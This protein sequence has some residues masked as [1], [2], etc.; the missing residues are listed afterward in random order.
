MERRSPERRSIP[1]PP[2]WLN[3][4]L[5]V[6]AGATFAYA[7]HQRNVIVE[8]S[9]VLFRKSENSPSELNRIRDELAQMDLT[10][11]QLAGELAGRMAFLQSLQ[12]EE[13]YIS[14][15]TATKKLQFRLGKTIVREAPV[16]IGP[17]ATIKSGNRIWTFYPLNVTGKDSDY[18]WR[19]P[20][21]VYAIRKAPLPEHRVARNWLG[22]YVIILP[23]NYVIHS[24]PPPE[25]PLQ[26]PKPGSFMVPEDDLAAIWPRITNET[27]VYIF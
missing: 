10:R 13:F 27:R 24:P 5:L 7:K 25:S 14:I 11:D 18:V 20:D 6:I 22:R 4:L 17:P 16:E 12:G 1:R 8:K 3:L 15:D 23:N 19:V 26:G 2:L 21:W 9:A